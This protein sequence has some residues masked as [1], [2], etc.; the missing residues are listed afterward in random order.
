M[1]DLCHAALA[2][3]NAEALLWKYAPH[4]RSFFHRH[5]GPDRF[6]AEFDG[7]LRIWVSLRDHIESMVYFHEMQEGDRGL[8]RLLMRLWKPGDVFVDIGANIGVFSLMAAKRLGDD[9][10]VHAFEPVS[11]SFERLK[12]N[13]ALNPHLRIVAH[14]VGLSDHGGTATIYVPLHNNLGMASLHPFDDPAKTE[15]IALSTLDEQVA[16]LGLAR[17]DIVKIDVEGH[18]LSVLKGGRQS[19]ERF[20][21]VVASE[22]AVNH[23]RRAGVSPEAVVAFMSELGYRWLGIDDHGRFVP[24]APLPEHGNVVFWPAERAEPE[25][26]R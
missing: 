21:P 24:D 11:Q 17:I 19:L 2:D 16:V 1:R 5:A 7:G 3:P 6:V 20:R 12:A 8:V 13:L 4:Y 10:M 26:S 14:R 18:E 9:G 15:S 22:L 23:L 25:V